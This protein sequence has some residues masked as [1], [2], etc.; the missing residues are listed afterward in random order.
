MDRHGSQSNNVE[1]ILSSPI[2]MI[3]LGVL[4]LGF[5][6]IVYEL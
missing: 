4:H 1:Q 2:R 3:S 5:S 6:G